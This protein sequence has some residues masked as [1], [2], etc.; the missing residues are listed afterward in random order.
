MD[1]YFATV[2][3]DVRHERSLILLLS[4]T[5]PNKLKHSKF[6]DDDV[7]F[8]E[9]YCF[10]KLTKATNIKRG[11]NYRFTRRRLRTIFSV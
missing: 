2:F 11:N 6:K 10:R 3:E 1:Q 4:L 8:I 5:D 9:K 7:N